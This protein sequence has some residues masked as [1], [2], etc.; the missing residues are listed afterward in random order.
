MLLYALKLNFFNP[1]RDECCDIL[2]GSEIDAADSEIVA[3]ACEPWHVGQSLSVG[4]YCLWVGGR[5]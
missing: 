1:Q 5:E 4:V 3:T 2:I